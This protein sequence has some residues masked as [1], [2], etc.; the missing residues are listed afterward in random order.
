MSVT[1][2]FL[3]N[4][5]VQINLDPT[6]TAYS[7]TGFLT[8]SLGRSGAVLS[9]LRPG[10]VLLTGVFTGGSPLSLRN[11]RFMSLNSAESANIAIDLATNVTGEIRWGNVL[12]YGVL[13]LNV[14]ENEWMPSVCQ[15]C[16]SLNGSALT[17][18][19][20]KVDPDRPWQFEAMKMLE[21]LA[22]LPKGWDSY[23][24]ERLRPD[25]KKLA[26]KLIDWIEM[27][28]LPVPAVVLCSAG[29]VQFEWKHQGR[30]LEIEVVSHDSVEYLVV[31]PSGEMQEGAITH[32][33]PD[34]VRQLT[35]GCCRGRHDLSF[36]ATTERW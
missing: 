28:D 32:D 16:E 4:T 2:R 26:V 5:S 3:E 36:P 15:L 14:R 10:A 18:K 21:N 9:N 20:Y 30:E 13:P 22:A 7:L 25:A 23:G 24:G 1:G 35:N 31:H 8:S 12:T 33:L 6:H 27:D 19:P 11:S 34:K 17:Q 29:T